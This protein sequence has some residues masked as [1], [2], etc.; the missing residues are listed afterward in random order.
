V[1]TAIQNLG[2]A[3]APMVI[4]LYMPSPNCPTY[5]ACVNSY[6]NVELILIGTGLVGFLSGVWLNIVDCTRKDGIQVL[7]WTSKKVEEKR[8][9]AIENGDDRKPFEEESLLGRLQ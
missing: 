3:A 8:K 2:L 9:E 4:G 5:D 1:A 6:N 7:N